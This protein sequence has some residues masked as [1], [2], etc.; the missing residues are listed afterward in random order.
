MSKEIILIGGGGHCKACI[1]VIETENKFKVA[2]IIDVKEKLGQK[3][4]NYKVIGCDEDLSEL[5]KNY[6]Y[7]LITMGQIKN[8][9]RRKEIFQQLSEL[10]TSFPVIV[11]PL[12]YVSQY[13]FINQGTIIMHKAIVNADAK[14]GNNCIINTSALIE[15]DTNIGNHCH[16]S[17]GAIVNGNSLIEDEVF[18]GSNAVIANNLTIAKN[19]IVGAGSV[20]VKSIN[21]KG[22]YVGKPACRIN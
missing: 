16:I 21:Q 13:A 8:A 14:V 22:T 9:D 2:G 5:V 15:H 19:A 4:L 1:D 18:I 20:V 3:V 7:F 11:S 6:R 10:D 12:A 17:T